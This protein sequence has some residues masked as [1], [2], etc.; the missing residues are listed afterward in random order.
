MS[1]IKPQ[2][3]VGDKVLVQ[4]YYN[5][6]VTEVIEVT[7]KGL[8]K[9]KD[10]YWSAFRQDGKSYLAPNKEKPCIRL[11]T[12]EEESFLKKGS[13]LAGILENISKWFKEN[14]INYLDEED[15]ITATESFLRALN[16]FDKVKENLVDKSKIKVSKGKE[17]ENISKK[18]R[19]RPKKGE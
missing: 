13:E 18:K 6:L 19:G 7:P 9:I 16:K 8:V 14:W 5:P 11:V 17:T 10:G 2:F 15:F 4:S 12:P 1:K 3:K